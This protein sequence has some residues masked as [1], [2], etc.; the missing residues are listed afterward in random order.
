M[1]NQNLVGSIVID[2]KLSE[3]L[4]E[5]EIRYLKNHVALIFVFCRWTSLNKISLSESSQGIVLIQWSFITSLKENN[6]LPAL[7]RCFHQDRIQ[8]QKLAGH[9][10]YWIVASY[11]QLNRERYNLVIFWTYLNKNP[12][13]RASKSATKIGFRP[14]TWAASS[15]YRRTICLNEDSAQANSDKKRKPP[16]TPPPNRPIEGRHDIE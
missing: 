12:Y 9:S 10:D 1:R 11:I 2:I 3:K 7:G 16:K 5:Q 6:W 15:F 4:A 14:G 8:T 13:F